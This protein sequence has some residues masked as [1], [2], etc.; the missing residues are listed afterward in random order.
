[1][2]FYKEHY[3]FYIGIDL[4]ARTMVCV[5]DNDGDIVFHKNMAATPDC[6]QHVILPYGTDR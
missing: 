4:N 6:L 3:Q 2:R 1:M 5:M